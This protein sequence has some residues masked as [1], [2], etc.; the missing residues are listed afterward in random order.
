MWN[1]NKLAKE[2][3]EITPN[4][5]KDGKWAYADGVGVIK[6]RLK[7]FSQKFPEYISNYT[8]EDVI[9]AY[10]K[11]MKDTT[12]FDGSISRYRKLLKYFIWKQEDDGDIS[13]ILCTYLDNKDNEMEDIQS[14][15]EDEIDWMG[16]VV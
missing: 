8:E 10:E 5:K 1:F 16:K 11:Y 6:M 12:N 2:L 3:K 9:K 15:S 7:S 14:V 4:A 13:S